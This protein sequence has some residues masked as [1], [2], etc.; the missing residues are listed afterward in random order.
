MDFLFQPTKK[1]LFKKLR[2]TT[3]TPTVTTKSTATGANSGF[4]FFLP[5]YQFPWEDQYQRPKMLVKNT[6]YGRFDSYHSEEPFYDDYHQ[7]MPV[8]HD[9]L[10]P[11][12]NE[13]LLPTV[14]FL[15]ILF[16]TL[17]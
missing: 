13:H 4:G 3:S 14:P 11:T 15:T 2:K 7:I 17:G 10:Q 16:L 5:N 6:R 1:K 12:P 9:Y 8:Y